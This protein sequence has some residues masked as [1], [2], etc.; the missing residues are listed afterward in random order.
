MPSVVTE[1]GELPGQGQVKTVGLTVSNS[2]KVAQTSTPVQLPVDRGHGRGQAQERGLWHHRRPR[3]GHVPVPPAACP[4]RWLRQTHSHGRPQ[5]AAAPA[6]GEAE[7]KSIAS[8]LPGA[9]PTKVEQ[10]L[11]NPEVAECNPTSPSPSSASAATHDHQSSLSH[12]QLSCL[13]DLSVCRGSSWNI[14]ALRMK[15]SR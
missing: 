1:R 9:E 3:Q 14:A 7:I 13:L 10:T 6:N 15:S 2:G 8:S 4:R 5:R 12:D 11:A